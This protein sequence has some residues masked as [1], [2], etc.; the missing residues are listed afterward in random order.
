MNFLVRLLMIAILVGAFPAIA[1]AQSGRLRDPGRP[2]I[3]APDN[4]FQQLGDKIKSDFTKETGVK[5][6]GDVP[7]DLLRAL[8]AKLLPD[9]QYALK[10]ATATNNSITATCYQ[11][12]I[13][14]ITT[15]Q[16][17]VQTKNSDGTTTDIAIP[18]PHL[19][20]DFE[21]A[22]ELRN[23]LQPDSK[24]MTSCSPVANLIK[25]DVLSFMGKVV[26]GGAGIAA[27]VPGL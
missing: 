6:T 8:D 17:A 22:V 10:L 18:D 25:Q 16:T 26:G 20:T 2:Q 11:A 13:D 24:F 12:W 15:Q 21:R 7:F 14:M 5:A 4:P 9:L 19:V 23:A 3:T 27:L 1:S